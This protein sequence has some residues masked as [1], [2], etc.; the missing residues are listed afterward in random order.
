MATDC[1]PK[2]DPF[3]AEERD[4]VIVYFKDKRPYYY[5]F[6]GTQFG[7]GAP[8]STLSLLAREK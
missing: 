7:I 4:K 6:V 5:P 8:I 1:F 2:P 3:T